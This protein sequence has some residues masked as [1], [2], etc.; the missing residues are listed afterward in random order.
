MIGLLAVAVL[1]LGGLWL[2]QGTSGDPDSGDPARQPAAVSDGG[3]A[4]D[5]GGEPAD[6]RGGQDEGPGEASDEDRSLSQA[7]AADAAA[8]WV[9]HSLST[10]DWQEALQPQVTERAWPLLA[11]PDPQR[12]GPEE[13][14]GDPVPVEVNASAAEYDVPTDAGKLRVVVVQEEEGKWLVSSIDKAV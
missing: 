7:R 2:F 4:S 1:I 13:V 8:V 11:L 14:T 3:G 9:D 12:V 5:G 10:A 6:E